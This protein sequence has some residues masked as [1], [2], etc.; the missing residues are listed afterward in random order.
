MQNKEATDGMP[1]FLSMREGAT[2]TIPQTH[3]DREQA[4][5]NAETKTLG[6]LTP[7]RRDLNV[8]SQSYKNP[9]L[10]AQYVRQC[11]KI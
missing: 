2:R 6:Y 9:K 10:K 7:W 8:A 5:I 3:K 11:K 1:S 4:K